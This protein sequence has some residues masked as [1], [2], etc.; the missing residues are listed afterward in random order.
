MHINQVRDLFIINIIKA[1]QFQNWR[2]CLSITLDV[3]TLPP[4]PSLQR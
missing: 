4:E 1:L 3:Q 2:L